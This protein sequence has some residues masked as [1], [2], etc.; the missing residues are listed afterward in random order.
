MATFNAGGGTTFLWIAEAAVLASCSAS[1]VLHT[2]LA[3]KSASSCGS[4]SDGNTGLV[5]VSGV[6]G[7]GSTHTF[8]ITTPIATAGIPDAG[9]VVGLWVDKGVTLGE[10]RLVDDS[11]GHTGPVG[12]VWADDTWMD[13]LLVA[14][15]AGAEHLPCV[16]ELGGALFNLTLS[17]L[18]I[19]HCVTIEVTTQ[20]TGGSLEYWVQL[21][22]DSSTYI[23]HHC[24][25]NVSVDD[26]EETALGDVVVGLW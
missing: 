9:L 3:L 10:G 6:S 7:D 5:T 16:T 17:C 22:V 8:A 26:D 12:T 2:V 23:P 20:T 13:W 14:S 11:A 1:I 15:W 19:V 18:Q 4:P 25:T 21:D 24:Q